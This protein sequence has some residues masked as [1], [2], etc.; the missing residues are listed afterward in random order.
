MEPQP[1]CERSGPDEDG[2]GHVGV[3][4][5]N[6]LVAL[7]RER[8]G[9]RR[10][11]DQVHPQPARTREPRHGPHEGRE[12]DPQ[13]RVELLELDPTHRAEEQRLEQRL[14]ERVV[15]VRRP[16]GLPGEER[17]VERAT[18]VKQ[19]QALV[20]PDRP[21]VAHGAGSPERGVADHE[22]RRER[23]HAEARGP[24]LETTGRL[25]PGR[26]NVAGISGAPPR[27]HDSGRDQR[28]GE[29]A[30]YGGQLGQRDPHS[31][32]KPGKEE[33]HHGGHSGEIGGSERRRHLPHA[34]DEA[35]RVQER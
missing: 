13:L 29:T 20:G 19:R 3:A 35:E 14:E 16:R 22:E 15:E 30:G 6:Q 2:D 12:Q 21:V 25:G 24:G 32:G 33:R 28:H 34:P 1:E 10:N 8:E 23:R 11:H 5:R 31:R 18:E 26:R 27:K 9:G 4:D 17:V 7:G